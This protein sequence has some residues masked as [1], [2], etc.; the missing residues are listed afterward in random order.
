MR[1]WGVGWIGAALALAVAGCAEPEPDVDGIAPFVS[2]ERLRARV[3][4]AGE[5][6]TLFVAWH[7][8]SLGVDC[9]FRRAGDGRQRC[10][11]DSPSGRV[12]T[13]EACTQRAHVRDTGDPRPAFVQGVLDEC[14]R[15]TVVY[16]SGT[17][18]ADAPGYYWRHPRTGVCEFR[19]L[20][21]DEQLFLLDQVVEPSSFV[22]AREV[23][24]QRTETID[25]HILAADDGASEIIGPHDRRRGEA[26]RIGWFGED[27]GPCLPTNLSFLTGRYFADAG[28]TEAVVYSSD[29][30]CSKPTVAAEWNHSQTEIGATALYEVGREL[31]ASEVYTIGSDGC[32][33]NDYPE[34]DDHRY[35]LP[36]AELAEDRFTA[37][38]REPAG[39]GPVRVVH[40]N[41]PDGV[42]LRGTW[43]RH[44]ESGRL[45]FDPLMTCDGEL[46]CLSYGQVSTSV[47]FRDAAC[48]EPV[49]AHDCAHEPSILYTTPG[50]SPSCAPD[51]IGTLY[52]P[53]AAYDG[54]T[55]EP[56]S[57][58]NCTP[59]DP[60]PAIC[61]RQLEP[62][63]NLDRF[64]TI[65]E[66]IE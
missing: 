47:A 18:I 26:C 29:S 49:G 22:G 37:V 23:R 6:G 12:Y 24:R 21:D 33:P 50:R 10:L 15:R 48:T 17:L 28:C 8:T 46:R 1:T 62:D 43:L 9:K 13:D 55:Y 66:R 53:A 25:A 32:Q 27:E 31:A 34:T 63:T 61:Y 64:G 3:L 4:D 2:G 44:T 36:G 41:D 58:G 54:P 38:R 56:D 57:L 45:C 59:T 19:A 14:D 42:P 7:D 51:S 65:T 16:L 30:W 5:G 35:F 40:V 11:P 52:A 39:Q 60:D 20:P